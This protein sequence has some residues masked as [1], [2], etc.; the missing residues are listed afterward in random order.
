[1]AKVGIMRSQKIPLTKLPS[2]R[3][4]LRHGIYL[5]ERALLEEDIDIKD[6]TVFALR[7]DSD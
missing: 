3:I 7:S 2:L 1:M 4:I 6:L 5:Q